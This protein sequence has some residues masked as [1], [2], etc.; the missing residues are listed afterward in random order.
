MIQ[1]YITSSYYLSCHAIFPQLR[2]E[3]YKKKSAPCSMSRGSTTT[4]GQFAYFRPICTN[5]IYRYHWSTEEWKE[6]PQSP[7][8]NSDITVIDGALTTIGGV[9]GGCHTSKLFTLQQ[10]LWVE[11]Y[12]VMNTE[13]SGRAVVITLDGNYI[14]AIG[15][16]GCN[17]SNWIPP[18]FMGDDWSAT[19]ELFQVSSGRWYKLSN[20]PRALSLPSATICGNQLHVIGCDGYGY[21]CSVDAL[22]S[23]PVNCTSQSISCLLKWTP[24]PRLPV[25][26]STAATLF[27]QLVII[28]GVRYWQRVN[29]I[30]QLVDGQWVKIGTLSSGSYRCMCFVVSP[31]PDK[32]MILGSGRVREDDSVEECVVV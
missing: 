11:K 3:C 16:Y 7:Y 22:P 10:G 4:D 29:S 23:V 14:I 6:L 18:V 19:V 30:H 25:K 13:L 8:Y 5:S 32:L 9:D 31:S 2:V 24:L 1:V 21:S 20:L 28:G 26:D 12:S 27:G 15:G 17:S